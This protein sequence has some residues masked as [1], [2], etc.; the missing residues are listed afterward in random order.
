MNTIVR[1]ASESDF[2]E[3]HILTEQIHQLHVTNRPDIYANVDSLSREYFDHLIS[4]PEVLALVAKVDQRVVGFCLTVIRP[5]SENPLTVPNITAY[6]DNL[7]VHQDYRRLG[8]GKMLFEQ[9][10]LQ[11]RQRGAVRLELH[12]AAFNQS[13]IR[14]YEELGMTVKNLAMEINL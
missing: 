5:P 1:E 8:I 13:A 9:A 2:D 7:C 4:Q 3:I 14:F 6:M 11:A 12:V 10:V